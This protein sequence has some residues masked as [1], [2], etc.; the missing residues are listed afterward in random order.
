MVLRITWGRATLR[1][2]HDAHVGQRISAAADELIEKIL[3]AAASW[4]AEAPGTLTPAIRAVC[5]RLA[6]MVADQRHFLQPLPEPQQSER[7]AMLSLVAERLRTGPA[8]RELKPHLDALAE[9]ELRATGSW[10]LV[11][12]ALAEWQQTAIDYLASHAAELD[13]AE[14]PDEYWADD[15]VAGV[16]ASVK[17][18]IGAD[19]LY[20][21]IESQYAG[22]GRPKRKD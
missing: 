22:G 5:V 13:D 4:A 11:A 16:I 9:R 20:T 2:M 1:P 19:D 10:S 15:V 12:S 21:R 14:R 3:R 18:L 17:G 8:A 7:R 6:E